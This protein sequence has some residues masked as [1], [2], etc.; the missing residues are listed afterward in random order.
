VAERGFHRWY[1]WMLE[2]FRSAPHWFVRAQAAIAL[3]RHQILKDPRDIVERLDHGEEDTEV[4][5]YGVALSY[6]RHEAAIPPLMRGMR[7]S[8]ERGDEASH[9]L[10]A[11]ALT[12]IGT[13][14]AEAIRRKWYQ[15]T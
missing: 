2:L 8:F 15:R 4:P 9:E 6:F 12:R 5:R 10:Y 1:D 11:A 14:A 3:C 7:R 13:P